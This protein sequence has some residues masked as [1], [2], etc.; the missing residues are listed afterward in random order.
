[1]KPYAPVSYPDLPN[2]VYDLFQKILGAQVYI[3]EVSEYCPKLHKYK[4][5][6]TH[7]TSRF[8]SIVVTPDNRLD[9]FLEEDT[10]NALALM[11]WDVLEAYA[12]SSIH[13]MTTNQD[14]IH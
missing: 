2:K 13:A 8:L 10:G 3:P 7:K 5:L 6:K 14:P 9:H 1:M 12:G 11:R 4:P